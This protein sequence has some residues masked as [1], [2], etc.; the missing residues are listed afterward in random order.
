MHDSRFWLGKMSIVLDAEFDMPTRCPGGNVEQAI[1][2]K[3]LEPRERQ[4][5]QTWS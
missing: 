5:L 2:P 1:A 4:K 3:G